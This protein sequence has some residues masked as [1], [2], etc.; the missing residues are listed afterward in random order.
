[1]LQTGPCF[2]HCR[3]EHRWN[4]AQEVQKR[5]AESGNSSPMKTFCAAF[6]LGVTRT[7]GGQ[8][9]CWLSRENSALRRQ[10]A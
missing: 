6:A 8:A 1:M 3:P 9:H 4:M 7:H 5:R 10:F 2:L